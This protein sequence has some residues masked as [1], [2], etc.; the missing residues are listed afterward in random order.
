[1]AIRNV[2]QKGLGVGILVILALGL[3]WLWGKDKPAEKVSAQPKRPPQAVAVTVAPVT[4][5]PI[6]RKVEVV[7]TLYGSEEVVVTPKVEGRVL[8]LHHDLGDMVRPGDLLLEI[9]DIDYRLAVAEAQKGLELELAKLGLKEIPEKGFDAQ[10][11]PA[12]ARAKFLRDNAS[13]KLDRAKTLVRNRAASVE[14]LQ[15]AQTDFE[16][17]EASYHQAILEAQA[18][19]AAARHRLA[20]RNTAQQR[21]DET[22]VVVPDLSLQRRKLIHPVAGKEVLPAS[23]SNPQP[24]EFVVA[25]RMVSEG[26]MVRAFPSMA[27][28]K[29]V[30]DRTLK[31]QATVP[32]R[33][34]AVIQVNQPVDLQVEAF[35]GQVFQ[36]IVARV[37]PVIDR[38]NRT[39]QIEI[40]V[41]NEDRKLRAG[42]FVR[43]AIATRVEASV[44]TVPEEALVRFAGVTKIFVVRDN[45]AYEIK[46]EPGVRLEVNGPK[47]VENWFEVSTT[48][49]A[50]TQVVTSGQSQLYDGSP[51]RIREESKNEPRP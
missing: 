46:V 21:L 47:R 37:N 6:Q 34:S 2:L 27:A 45:H 18:T 16:V 42:S 9:E 8:K 23:A 43:A 13:A 29:L 48:L 33:H 3:V 41:P 32:E 31:L 17:A 7:G 39:F 20:V 35:P 22:R 30:L 44:P 14:E 51:I 12:V 4:P 24:I 5:R 15:Q 11:V 49:P 40:H 50:E 19:L 1:M 10:Q 25:A 28:F 38:T 36:G 26:E